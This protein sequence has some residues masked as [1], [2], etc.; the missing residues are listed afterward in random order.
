MISDIYRRARVHQLLTQKKPWPHRHI[1]VF[2][3]SLGTVGKL[4]KST[5]ELADRVA[6]PMEPEALYVKLQAKVFKH[7]QVAGQ[8]RRSPKQLLDQSHD[9]MPTLR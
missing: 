8:D 7:P 4:P 9:F 2:S 3:Q 1:L 6:P 5:F